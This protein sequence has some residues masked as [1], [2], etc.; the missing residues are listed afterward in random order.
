MRNRDRP[1]RSYAGSNDGLTKFEETAIAVMQGELANPS[2]M[3]IVA[4]TAKDNKRSPF[5]IVAADALFQAEALWDEIEKREAAEDEAPGGSFAKV[6]AARNETNA[7]AIRFLRDA[8]HAAAADAL[9]SDLE[10]PF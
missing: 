7:Y 1:A 4:T 3:A 8:G 5:D 2:I 9:Q 6:V 10:I